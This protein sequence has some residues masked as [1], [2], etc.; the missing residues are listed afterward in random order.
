MAGQFL[1]LTRLTMGFNNLDHLLALLGRS[2]EWEKLRRYQLVQKAWQKVVDP[3]L[4]ECTKP[5]GIQRGVL[6]VAVISPALAQNLQLQRTNLLAKLN[7]EL[8]EPLTDLR[9]SPLHWHQQ[10]PGRQPEASAP[11]GR[12]VP[13]AIGDRPQKPTNA[14]QALEQWLTTLKKRAQVLRECPQC[15]SA[16]NPGEVERWGRCRACARQPWQEI[17]SQSRPEKDG[18]H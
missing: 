3:R 13:P 18:R 16:V 15:H 12:P 10:H 1:P 17:L 5:L 11:M 14:E 4:W 6:T 2:P 9:L 8:P 7:R